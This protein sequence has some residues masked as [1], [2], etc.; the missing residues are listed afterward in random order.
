MAL[1]ATEVFGTV[2]PGFVTD[3]D[4]VLSTSAVAEET[5]RG[6]LV[7]GD[8]RLVITETADETVLGT[9]VPGFLTDENG[10]LVV[11]QDD[12]DAVYGE[13][14]PGFWT[15]PTGA[16]VV[17]D[18]PEEVEWVDGFVRTADG[19]LAVNYSYA[20]LLQSFGSLGTLLSLDSV[21]GL[22]DLSGNGNSGTAVGTPTVGGYTP[23]PLAVGD[24]GATDL[25]GSNQY[26]T[27]TYD[28]FVDSR[29][30][31]FSGWA[32]RDDQDAIHGLMGDSTSFT[33]GPRFESGRNDQV[34]FWPST[35]LSPFTFTVAEITFGQWFHW[36]LVFDEPNDTSRF[37]LNGTL[38]EEVVVAS[39]AWHASAT[40]FRIGIRGGGTIP[41]NGK[42]AWVAV[43]ET[44]LSPEQ[45]AAAAALGA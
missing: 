12:T 7:D 20:S 34:K 24:D 39:T 3:T 19:Y 44:G 21:S 32:I 13:V 9:V 22:T 15:S 18:G 35:L 6:F 2:T 8:G 28:A 17:E 43:H 5:S 38:Q 29:A 45:I 33:I 26:V 27:T 37:Y 4:G 16:L 42:Q 40:N 30:T 11:T 41:W 23:G 1:A 31:T 14:V 10:A 36:A 25:N